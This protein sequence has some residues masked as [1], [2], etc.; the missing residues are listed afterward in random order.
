[1]PEWDLFRRT[2]LAWQLNKQMNKAMRSGSTDREIMEGRGGVSA[3]DQIQ[4]MR[5]VVLK[6]KPKEGG[7]GE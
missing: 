4:D 3:V 7:S 1:M 2:V 6:L 5:D